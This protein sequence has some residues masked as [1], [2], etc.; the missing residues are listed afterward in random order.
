MRGVVVHANRCA[1]GCSVVVGITDEDVGVVLLVVLLEGV[2]DVDASVVRPACPVPREP[3][4][5][6]HRAV[7]LRRDEVEPADVRVVDEDALAEP[8]WAEP[9]RIDADEELA[10]AL[11]RLGERAHLHDLPTGAD[12]DVAVRAVVGPRHD[13]GCRKRPD[14]SGAVDL[15]PE[16]AHRTTDVDDDPDLAFAR[17]DRGLIDEPEETFVVATGRLVPLRDAADVRDHVE[18]QPAVGGE[19]DWEGVLHVEEIGQEEVSVPVEGQARITAG[20]AEVVVV[21]DELGRPGLP[22]V[23]AHAF[24]QPRGRKVDVRDHDDVLRIRRVDGDRRFGLVRVALADVDVGRYRRRS[25]PLRLAGSRQE[26]GNTERGT[27][28]GDDA[29]RAHGLSP[30]PELQQRMELTPRTRV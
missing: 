4:L 3:R 24:E 16:C 25:R 7:G 14:L 27:E 8:R 20:I 17:R 13:L 23:E 30:F 11:T 6:V 2:G 18:G 28:R 29:T 10:A 15:R 19:C 1:P 5:G 26:K 22:A 9:V 12:R 21:A